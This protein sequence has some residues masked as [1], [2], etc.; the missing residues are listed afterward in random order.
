MRRRFLPLVCLLVLFTLFLTGPGWSAEQSP[1]VT[2]DTILIGVIGPLTGP[3]S[4]SGT[5][6]QN[7]ALL[8]FDEVNE[9]GGVNGRKIKAIVEDDKCLPSDGVAATRKLIDRDKV[10]ALF[11]GVCSN[12]T[13]AGLPLI[14]ESGIPFQDVFVSHPSLTT[15][16]IRNIFRVGSIPS[17]VHAYYMV[18]FAIQHFKAKKIAIVNQSDE[19]G[20]YGDQYLQ[21]WMEKKYH[22]KPV[23]HEVYNLGDVDFTSQVVRLK[24]ADPDVVLLYGFPKE[25]AILLRQSKELGLNAQWIG[26]MSIADRSFTLAAGEAGLGSVHL[27][28][29]G[30]YLE[31][32]NQPLVNQFREK[33]EKKYPNHPPG[34]PHALDMSAYASAKVFVEGLRRAGKDL[35]WEG[36]IKAMESIRVFDSGLMGKITFTPTDHQG[37]KAARFVINESGGKRALIGVTLGE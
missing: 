33:Y 21:E 18:D 5:S 16:V 22:M 27:W 10:F 7:G 34:K 37:N 25:S 13:L 11:G 3:A 1:G 26:S 19:F 20:K 2:A 23:A 29:W 32:D 15:P 36:F 28:N 4:W 6:L 35:T 30:P 12:A 8:Y 14:K 31:T 17:D 24:N 9:S